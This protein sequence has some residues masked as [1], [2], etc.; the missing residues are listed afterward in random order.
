MDFSSEEPHSD[1]K[2]TK[3]PPILNSR[4]QPQL[5]VIETDEKYVENLDH[6]LA[7]KVKRQ[8][9]VKKGNNLFS[10]SKINILNSPSKFE[11]PPLNQPSSSLLITQV[12]EESIELKQPKPSVYTFETAQK[13]EEYDNKSTFSSSNVSYLIS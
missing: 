9:V 3:L 6:W 11:S 7:E 1:I 4:I 12:G 2:K 13:S 5:N 8:K 10:N